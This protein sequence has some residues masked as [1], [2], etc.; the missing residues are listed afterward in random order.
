[1]RKIIVSLHVSLDGFVAGS[2]GEMDCI[3][4]DEVMFDMVA[5]TDEADIALHTRVTWK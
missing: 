2:K 3:K 4:L 1:M 5:L